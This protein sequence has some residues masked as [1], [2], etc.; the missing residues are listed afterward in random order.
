MSRSPINQ[1]PALDEALASAGAARLLALDGLR[2]AIMIVM[3]LDHANALIAHQHPP[4]EIWSRSPPDY[5]SALAFLTRLVTHL[6]APG[7]FWLL[8]AGMILFADARRRLGWSEGGI[9]RHLGLRGVLL[10]GLQL[11]VENPAWQIGQSFRIV[12]VYIGVLY[13]L[14]GAMIVGALLLRLPALVLIALGAAAIAAAHL[15]LPAQPSAPVGPIARLLLIPG[16]TEPVVVNYPLIPWLGVAC[17]GMAFGRWLLA[18]R[19]GAYGWALPIGAASL[20]LFVV[21]RLLGGLGNIRP[22]EGTGWIAF[23]NVVKYPPSLVFLLLTLGAELLILGLLA[24]AGD[25]LA[26]WGRPLLVFGQSAL[27][28][29]IAHLYLYGLIGLVV[30]PAGMPI[31]RMY[32]FW[33]AGLVVLYF[34]CRWYSA[35]KR[36]QAPESL[37][38]LL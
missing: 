37:W 19:A 27:L 35:F 3:A 33:L 29:Y 1:S 8:G 14:G 20:A 22:A 4:A 24:R 34:V 30:A 16:L 28:F 23:L 6:A 38:R 21:L 15:L 7:F 12:P 32:P 36:R 18:D 10:I 9:R 5:T 11:L 25:R 31:A 2:G 13:A 17:L 26:A